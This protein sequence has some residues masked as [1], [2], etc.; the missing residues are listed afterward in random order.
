MDESLS[1]MVREK[2]E[3]DRQ[4]EVLD[5]MDR[6]VAKTPGATTIDDAERLTGRSFIDLLV[7]ETG[8][9]VEQIEQAANT[10]MSGNTGDTGDTG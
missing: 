3:L 10:I 2:E 6:I 9:T 4:I 1:D 5:A 7:E 8:F